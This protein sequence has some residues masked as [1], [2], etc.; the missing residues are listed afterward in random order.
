MSDVIINV[1]VTEGGII[2][3]DLS[4][5]TTIETTIEQGGILEATLIGGSKGATG[6]TGA[7]GTT[8]A[9]GPI[10]ATGAGVPDGGT[11]DQVLR[12]ASAT[13]Q[14]TEWH[15][16][17]KAD[18]GLSNVDNTS[19]AGKPVSTAQATAIGVVQTDIDNHEANTSNPHSVTKTQVGLGNADN[20]S[21]V[22]KPVS[23]A[24]QTALDGKQ[25]TDADLTAIAALDSAT[26]GAIASDGA[27]WIKKTYAQFKT[28]LGLVKGDVGLG[29]VD[30]TA[31][32]DKPVSTAAQTALDAKQDEDADLTAIAALNSATAGMVASDGAGW[33]QKTYAQVKTALGLVK[34]DVGLGN[35]DNVQQQPIDSDLTTIAGLTATTDNFMVATASAWASR[36]PSQA[37][38]QLGLG[39]LATL[40]AVTEAEITLADNVTNDVSITKHGFVPKGT[41]TGKFLKDDGSWDAIPGGGDALTSSSLAQFAP[42]TSLQLKGVMSDET[43]SGLLV[44]GTAPAITTPTGIVKGDVGLGSVDNTSDAGKP[45][46]TAQQTALDGKQ[47]I[48]SDLTTIAGLTPTTDNFMVATASAWA[49]RTPTQARSQMGLGAMAT[50]GTV[51]T[52]DIDAGAVT[53][54]KMQDISQAARILGRQYGGTGGDTEE[55]TAAM[56]MLIIAVEGGWV[57]AGE[58]WTYASGAGTNSGTFTIAGVDLTGKYAAGMK[59]KFTQ[60]TVKYAFITKVAFSTDTT[61]TIYLGTDYTIANAAISANYHS[62]Q[63]APFGFPLNPAKWALTTTSTT[64]RSTTSATYATLTDSLVVPIGDWIIEF[65][66]FLYQSS[67]ATTNSNGEVILST[68]GSTLT[69]PALSMGNIKRSGTAATTSAN[70]ST[71]F[72]K[73]Y[74]SLAASTTFLMMGKVNSGAD[75]INVYNTNVLT[76]TVIKA[77]CAYL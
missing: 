7:T 18:V 17:V 75:A 24:T 33:I 68:D 40:S 42:T 28:A 53:Y 31:D 51:A 30:N 12:K 77:I 48:D 57:G 8:G 32:A 74:V 10:G 37:R 29:S 59:V 25:T 15:T 58:T 45:V 50:K 43:G 62:I 22:N 39:G 2:D 60:T 36:T 21:D 54:D 20:T 9:Q 49:S 19:D 73:D 76:S 34:G 44:F 5:A 35:V 55:L 65:K 23:S 46:S 41:N 11:D 27:G 13:D 52:A 69:N 6:D 38:T 63:K 64:N 72:A 3:A 66:A 71:G 14:D 26:S 56:A 70:G 4:S 61:I 16:P 47:P 67:A 1:T